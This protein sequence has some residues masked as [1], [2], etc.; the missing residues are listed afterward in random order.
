GGEQ[1]GNLRQVVP[2]WFTVDGGPRVVAGTVVGEGIGDLGELVDDQAQEAALPQADACTPKV[3]T[4]S[5]RP[6]AVP[7]ESGRGCTEPPASPGC[8]RFRE[9]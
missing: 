4:R 3:R 9:T 6:S 1:R 5:P 8:V 7:D 2:G